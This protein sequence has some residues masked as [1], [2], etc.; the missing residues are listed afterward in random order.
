M[1]LSLTLEQLVGFYSYWL[2]KSLS[3]I[4]WCLVNMNI[5]APK[6][7]ALQLDPKNQNGDFLEHVSHVILVPAT[8]QDYFVAS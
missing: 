6:I 3:I 7:G 8:E 5:L 4:R 1:Y 2:F